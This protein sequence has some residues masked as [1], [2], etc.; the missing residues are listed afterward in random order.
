MTGTLPSLEQPAPQASHAD[1]AAVGD[2]PLPSVEDVVLDFLSKIRRGQAPVALGHRLD[3]LDVPPVDLL[4]VLLA[5]EARFGVELSDEAL[6]EVQTVG[7]FVTLVRR[8]G[9]GSSTNY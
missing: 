3:A 8:A 6:E 1:A 2:Q 5:V 9:S 4:T 7:E